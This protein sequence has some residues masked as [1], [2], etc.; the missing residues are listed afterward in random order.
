MEFRIDRVPD[1]DY[2]VRI[3]IYSTSALS[4][5]FVQ[6]MI[7]TP[8]Q[9]AG[10]TLSLD[11]LNSPSPHPVGKKTSARCKQSASQKD[12]LLTLSELTEDDQDGN[13]SADRGIPIH[14]NCRI[15]F[16]L[17]Q[18]RLRYICCP[19]RH[20]FYSVF[21]QYRRAR[22]HYRTTRSHRRQRRVISAPSTIYTVE[23]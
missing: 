11:S 2:T 3:I 23:E 5:S 12:A 8:K 18:D 14:S 19:K 1:H 22:K 20:P 9:F 4:H 7:T 16:C 21:C 17:Y 10:S 15:C 6:T 13:A